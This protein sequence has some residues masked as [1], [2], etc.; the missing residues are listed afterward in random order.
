[1][2]QPDSR[3]KASKVPRPAKDSRR[4]PGRRQSGE[5]RP[6]ASGAYSTGSARSFETE[7]A[8]EWAPDIED[9]DGLTQEDWFDY[10]RS[11]HKAFGEL[12]T[13]EISRK[14]RH[15]DRG[16][17]MGKS[18]VHKTLEGRWPTAQTAYRLGLGIGGPGLAMQF[19][20]GWLAAD[21]KL[22]R[23]I[24]LRNMRHVLARQ[25]DPR[26]L[27][28]YERG[29]EERR[30]QRRRE[31]RESDR[32]RRWARVMVPMQIAVAIFTLVAFWLSQR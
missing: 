19:R 18:T 20:N 10:I 17:T 4:K 32:L 11:A 31:Q 21:G 27:E 1:M 12:S 14:A 2:M 25:E 6:E 26:A 22:R 3:R 5:R 13:R 16:C 9:F 30:E 15:Y 7:T 8:G 29:Q 24:H 28:L 23:E